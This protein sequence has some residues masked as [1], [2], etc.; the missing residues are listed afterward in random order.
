M[1]DESGASPD[2]GEV[3]LLNKPLTWTSFDAVNKI[4]RACRI[5]KIGHAGTLDPLATGLLILCTGKKTKE[6]DKYQGAEKEYTGKLVLG[7]TTPSIDLETPFDGE[8][9]TDHIT[10]ELMQAAVAKLTGE[11]AQYP[12]IYSAVKMGGERLYKKA[13]RG[14]VVEIKS[15]S[16]SVPVFEIDA[17]NFPEVSFRI[18][19]S[20]GTYIRSLVRDFGMLLESGAYMSELCRTRIGTYWLKDAEEI[21]DYVKRKRLELNLDLGKP[22]PNPESEI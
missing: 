8:Y 1:I 11:L 19:C 21:E 13:R 17:A 9:P 6:I 2:E 4:K 12:P 18:V 5:K 10:L 22:N 3:I 15:R 20:K 7:K 14:E 16:V